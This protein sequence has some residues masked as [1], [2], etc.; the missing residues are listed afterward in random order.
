M[1]LAVLIALSLH[2]LAAV[3][4][5]GTTFTLARTG[6]IGGERLFRPQMGAATLAVLT[7]SYVW[8]LLHEGSFGPSEQVLAVGVVAALIAA[9][10]QGALAGPASR[11]LRA[12]HDEAAARSRLA[13]AQRV[14]AVL[15]AV[16]LVC[17]VIARDV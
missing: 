12:G 5:V 10:V 8:H 15:L 14:T 11:R 16:T 3:F 1:P 6:G 17:M 2:A 9:G 4:W 13:L 7:G